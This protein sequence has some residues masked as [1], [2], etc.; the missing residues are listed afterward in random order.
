MDISKKTFIWI[1]AGLILLRIISLILLFNNIPFTDIQS[2]WRPHFSGSYWPDESVF[3][4]LAKSLAD[5]KPI[6]SIIYI[7]YAIFLAPFI[8]FTNATS[9]EMIAKIIVIVQGVILFSATL[10]FVAFIGKKFFRNK[11]LALISAALFLVY[12]YLMFVIWKLIG[13]KN[14]IPTFHYQMWIVILSDYLSAFFVILTFWLFIKLLEQFETSNSG[15]YYFT[16]AT[17]IFAGAAALVRPPNLAISAFLFLYLLYIRKHKPAFIFG[18]SSFFAYL[19]QLIY[20]THFFKWPWVYGNIVLDSGLPQGGSFFG[21]WVNPANFWINFKH[22]SPDHY[23]LFFLISA[24]FVTTIFILG[25]KY[26]TKT[27]NKFTTVFIFWF[28]F[29]ALFY[30][31]FSGSTSQLRYFLPAIPV[32]IYFFIAAV[33]YLYEIN[34]NVQGKNNL[35]SFSHL[36]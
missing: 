1:I 35:N 18:F 33:I 10:I 8:Y 12:P 22:F 20:N 19:P 3:F 6:M 4:N 11:K 15:I 25:W 32:F 34:K 28:L 5:F 2:N 29:Y 9:P 26:L 14:A 23:F 36:S 7:G 17:G 30:G 16:I 13:H 27:G 31:Q 21:H 24:I